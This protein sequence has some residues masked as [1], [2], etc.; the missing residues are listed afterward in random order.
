MPRFYFSCV[1]PDRSTTDVA[2]EMLRNR[3]EATEHARAI[4][5]ELAR[6]QLAAGE[7]PNGWVEVED[8]MH[9]PLFM[10]P[11]RAVAD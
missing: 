10:L 5:R 6:S 9:R 11:F 3:T 2:G 8:E 7:S 4:A 1:C